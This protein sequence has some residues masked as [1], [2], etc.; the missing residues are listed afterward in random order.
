MVKVGTAG[1]GFNSVDMGYKFPKVI[2]YTPGTLDAV[3]IDASEF[4]TNC[5]TVVVDQG[6][7][8]VIINK[9][10]YPTFSAYQFP[11][12][13]IIGEQLVSNQIV[14]DLYITSTETDA[15]NPD[16]I[17]VAGT[18]EL[19][20]GEIIVGKESGTVAN[21]VSITEN[22]GR[23]AVDYAGSKK[24]IGWSDDV[25]KLNLDNQVLPDNDYYQNLS[26]TVKSSQEYS[27]LRSPVNGLLHTAG[28]KN[29]ADTGISSTTALSA[30]GST[31]QSLSILDLTG[32]ERVDTLYNWTT[33]FDLE[34]NTT[35]GSN[36]TR[37][38]KASKF[39]EIENKRL[40]SYLLAK[41]N[42]VLIIDDI[43]SQFSNL[44][45]DPSEFLNLFKI[46]A[47]SVNEFE[48]LFVRVTDIGQGDVQTADL[49]LLSNYGTESVLLQKQKLNDET[50]IGNFRVEETSLGDTYLRFIPLPDAYN[51][52]YD[53]KVVR[54]QFNQQAGVGTFAVGFVNLSGSVGVIYYRFIRYYNYKNYWFKF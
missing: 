53:I 34:Y 47:S 5:G 42:Q 22:E 46:D 49:V 20:P 24:D 30:V 28:L 12:Q 18:Y 7:L 39:V 17:K 4:T 52:D 21:I 31:S 45:G 14:R 35:F 37:T 15:K 44:D 13:F 32:D 51:T 38:G 8:A 23:F 6:S 27:T 41:S 40:S 33:A 25:G 2:A 10:N 54:T 11:S 43:N 19:S 9:Y 3:T 16:I 26:Y 36:I 48:G 29:F 50:S 1:T